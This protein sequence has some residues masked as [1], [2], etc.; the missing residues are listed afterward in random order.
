MVAAGLEN[1]IITK[2][3]IQVVAY[4]DDMV[5]PR[6]GGGLE[7]SAKNLAKETNIEIL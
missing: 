6:S 2:N 1:S 4:A 7:K 5:A 3:N